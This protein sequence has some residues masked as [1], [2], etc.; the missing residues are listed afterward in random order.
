MKRVR[1]YRGKYIPPF[2][3]PSPSDLLAKKLG[4][5]D[6]NTFPGLYDW[7]EGRIEL[8]HFDISESVVISTANPLNVEILEDNAL[9]FFL[10]FKDINDIRRL[11]YSFI[12]VNQKLKTGG[13]FIGCFRGQEQWKNHFF[14][15]YPFIVARIFYFFHFIFK[16]VMPKMPFFKRIYFALTK[17]RNRV[18]SKAEVLGRLYYCGFSVLDIK[19]MGNSTWFIG[20]KVSPPR[21]DKSPSYGP[22][23]KM[24]RLG[25]GGKLIEV[26]KFRTM[27]PYSEYLQDL[28]T[29]LY[30]YDE[31][32]KVK[33]DFRITGWGRFLRK[34]WLDELPQSIN[35]LQGDLRLVGPRPLSLRYLENYPEDIR[36]ERLKYRPGCVPP[37]VAYRMQGLEESIEAERLYFDRKKKHPLRTDF[38]VFF[39]AL[40]NIITRRIV[41]K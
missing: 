21:E 30:G 31:K 35:L 29:D 2:S 13:V 26:Y 40:F 5:L 27:H 12:K 17:G 4:N 20:K 10:N 11:N 14:Q 22:V 7:I 6:L 41:S 32:G 39:M 1:L 37:Y 18:L 28:I 15:R 34:W 36:R 8:I 23:I 3:T 25:K 24:Q 38:Q 33:D 19:I 9:G 16:R